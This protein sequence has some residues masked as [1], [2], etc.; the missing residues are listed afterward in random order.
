MLA[1]AK[2]QRNSVSDVSVD[3][4]DFHLLLWNLVVILKA[5]YNTAEIPYHLC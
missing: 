1:I 2:P 4:M 3:V 5:S